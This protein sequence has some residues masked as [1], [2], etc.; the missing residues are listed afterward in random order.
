[1]LLGVVKIDWI[2][3][4]W[5]KTVFNLKIVG[6]SLEKSIY[7]YFN[8]LKKIQIS[9]PHWLWYVGGWKRNKHEYDD[10]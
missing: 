1:M 2:L 3:E 10:F 4:K 9:Y 8:L 6:T 7:K 5:F